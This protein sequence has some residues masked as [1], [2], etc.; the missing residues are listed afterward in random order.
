[1]QPYTQLSA[2]LAA[3]HIELP[4]TPGIQINS[5]SRNSQK[6][7]TSQEQQWSS[8]IAM[9]SPA[10]RGMCDHA[11]TALG[12]EMGLEAFSFLGFAVSPPLT[13]EVA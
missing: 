1:M 13:F 6:I 3:L 9:Q 4:A 12:L 10:H 8:F 11:S 7:M 2:S 5:V